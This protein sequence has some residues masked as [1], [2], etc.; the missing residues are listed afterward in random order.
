MRGNPRGQ[1]LP[2]VQTAEVTVTAQRKQTQQRKLQPPLRYQV[3]TAS[4]VRWLRL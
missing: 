2:R 4:F 1:F 3:L